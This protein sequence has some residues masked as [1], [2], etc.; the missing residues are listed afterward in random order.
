MTRPDDV[1]AFKVHGMDCAEEVAVLKQVVGPLVGGDD[2][3]AFDILNAK[4]IVTTRQDGPAAATITR[5]VA[6]T[7]MR[8]EPWQERGA[9]PA[10]ST[11]WERRGRTTLSA[12]SVCCSSAGS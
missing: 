8:A 6:S 9:I 3:L 10:E 12:A 11:F 2:R 7:G 1:L 4:M 5:A